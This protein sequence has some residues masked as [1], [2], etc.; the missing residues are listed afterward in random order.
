MEHTDPADVVPDGDLGPRPEHDLST[1]EDVPRNNPDG[2]GEEIYPRQRLLGIAAAAKAVVRY[3]RRYL[4]VLGEPWAFESM[5]PTLLTDEVVGQL[6][7]LEMWL[8]PRGLPFTSPGRRDPARI[9]KVPDENS[10]MWRQ[11]GLY[12]SLANLVRR[13]DRILEHYEV[14]GAIS[15]YKREPCDLRPGEI[16]PELLE[17]LEQ[18]AAALEGAA[19]ED[20]CQ[21]YLYELWEWLSRPRGGRPCALGIVLD[22]ERRTASREGCG[23]VG[24]RGWSIPWDL[25][26]LLARREGCLCSKDELQ[27]VWEK[28]GKKATDNT[29]HRHLSTLSRLLKDIGV[30]VRCDRKVG[31]RLEALPE[32]RAS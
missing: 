29:I 16:N 5:C 8:N 30:R 20:N 32:D 3:I 22:E 13:Y 1:D 4:P 6:H 27:A 12:S 23:S 9:M 21:G 31:Y 17:G 28:R 26:K 19:N 10:L 14:A 7:R 24:F 15:A 18:A 11:P 2:I 25:L